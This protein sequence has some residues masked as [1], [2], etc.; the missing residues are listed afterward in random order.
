[1]TLLIKLIL[2]IYLGGLEA[3]DYIYFVVLPIVCFLVIALV[4]FFIILSVCCFCIARRHS[5]NKEA[6]QHGNYLFHY[7]YM[8]QVY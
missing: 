7:E 1:M 3:T 2:C 5:T 4:I 6:P 8:I